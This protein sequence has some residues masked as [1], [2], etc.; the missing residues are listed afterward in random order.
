MRLGALPGP[1]A[2]PGA[3]R[4]AWPGALCGYAPCVA[5]DRVA[6]SRDARKPIPAVRMSTMASAMKISPSVMAATL[7]WFA[8]AQLSSEP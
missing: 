3:G 7:T 5:S 6:G 4:C 1:G 8:M 2:L